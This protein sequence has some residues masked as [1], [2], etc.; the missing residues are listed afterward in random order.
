MKSE[1]KKLEVQSA[2]FAKGDHGE[3]DNIIACNQAISLQ[4]RIEKR[5]KY[6]YYIIRQP[7]HDVCGCLK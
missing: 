3:N 1:F 6:S 4:L 2:K 7:Q 5:N